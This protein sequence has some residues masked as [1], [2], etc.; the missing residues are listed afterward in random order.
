MKHHIHITLL[1]LSAALLTWA[2]LPGE[3]LSMPPYQ[4]EPA[5][6]AS[7]ENTLAINE[8]YAELQEQWR[9]FGIDQPAEI[10]FQEWLHSTSTTAKN[11]LC[12]LVRFTDKANI[13]GASYFDT[14]VYINQVG[15]VRHYYN[16]VSFNQLD[17]V[18]VD[19]PSTIGWKLAPQAYSYYVNGEHGLNYYSYPRNCQK[20]V[21]DAV[22]AVDAVVDFSNYDN[23]SD[24]YV[25]G[26]MVVH[27]GR[28]AELT[29]SVNDIWS[30]KW[31]INPRLKDGK[32][33]Y[34]YSMMPEY[35]YV[36]ADMTL[37][38]FCHELGHVFGLPDL[39]DTDYT[40][41]GVGKWSIMASGSWN[42]SLGS[43]PAHFDAW[44]RLQLGFATSTN[45][46]STMYGASI[47]DVETSGTIYRLWTSGAASSEYFLVENR[48]KTGYDTA[49]PG[50]GLLIW[51]IDDT[52]STNDN[53]W[54]P[55]HTGYGN[56]LVALMQAD[57]NWGLENNTSSGDAG[58]PFP[59]TSN[60]TTFTPLTNPN[61]NA[62]DGS[63]TLVGATNISAAGPTMTADFFVSF[64][65]GA[66]DND[67]SLPSENSFDLAQNFPNP[68]NAETTIGFSVEG[69]TD[70]TF[71]ILNILGQQVIE[72]TMHIDSPGPHS[73]DWDGK[74]M[75]GDELPAGI[76]FYRIRL[77]TDE[78]S[79]KKMLF[80]K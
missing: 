12:I 48:R 50:E 18:T 72:E 78:M 56:Y 37:G 23:D 61:S 69:E 58:D 53:E 14:L 76:Y 71:E 57:N 38:V 80:L 13:T 7:S 44:S 34:T 29:H 11:M 16:E 1:L 64:A 39:Y 25:D 20:L 49:L 27:T 26:L 33:I 66:D 8:Q 68:F 79:T 10:D 67:P 47:P 43:S 65:S 59:G 3:A 70:A 41:N 62:Y 30:H 31:S 5:D 4:G 74:D 52:E 54:Y 6:K 73:F 55:G 17:I 36:A 28:G 22:D 2:L 24:G 63:N 77:D 46:T 75:N 45:V 21:E 35:W 60:N 32:Y 15:S 9:E 40:S 19:L 42:G 51:H